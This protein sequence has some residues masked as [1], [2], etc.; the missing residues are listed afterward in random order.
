ME[1]QKVIVAV[2]ELSAALI[3]MVQNGRSKY[4]RS[5]KDVGAFCK[6]HGS[7]DLH[8]LLCVYPVQDYAQCFNSVGVKSKKELEALWSK[9][10]SDEEVRCS[11]EAL[12]SAEESYES[13]IREVD[14]DSEIYEN[15][16]AL[17]VVRVGDSLQMDMSFVEARTGN[18]IPLSSL[19]QKATYTLFVLRKHYV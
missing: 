13:L 17:P 6:S 1:K 3:K 5:G 16:V 2:K 14:E 8:G 18:K 11:V 9:Y 10:F 15:K 19:L 7:D 4:E 12:I